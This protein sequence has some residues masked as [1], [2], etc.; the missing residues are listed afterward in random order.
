M[1][2][3]CPHCA[4]TYRIDPAKVPVG[5]V[6]ARCSVCRGV[7]E[8]GAAMDGLVQPALAAAASHPAQPDAMPEPAPADV[9]RGDPTTSPEDATPASRSAAPAD[10]SA[11]SDEATS[12]SHVTPIFGRADPKAKARRLARALVSDMA[13]YHP[14]RRERALRDGTLKQEFRDEIRKSW[15][16]YVDQVGPEVAHGTGHFREALNEILARGQVVF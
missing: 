7:F 12:S 15:Q 6:R 8:V 11:A 5:G 1:R 14:D 3:S 9:P 16:E 10:A 4:T 13:T 2:A